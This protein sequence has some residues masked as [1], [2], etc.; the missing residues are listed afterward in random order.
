MALIKNNKLRVH[1]VK[2][3]LYTCYVLFRV[4]IEAF[5]FEDKNADNN[6]STANDLGLI[7]KSDISMVNLQCTIDGVYVPRH[8][9]S[10]KLLSLVDNNSI[11]A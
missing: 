3:C 4:L 9:S 5:F 11:S 8:T 6:K 1:H 2:F 7:L 10:F